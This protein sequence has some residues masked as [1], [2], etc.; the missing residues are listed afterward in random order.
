[1]ADNIMHACIQG[2]YVYVHCPV[3]E[4][5]QVFETY[6]KNNVKRMQTQVANGLPE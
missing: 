4:P 3:L 2:G 1:M 6:T 5:S